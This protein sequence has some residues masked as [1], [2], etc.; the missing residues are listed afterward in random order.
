MIQEWADFHLYSSLSAELIQ[1]AML[2]ST[3]NI[4]QTLTEPKGNYGEKMSIAV[5]PLGPLAIPYVEE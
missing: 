2:K 3:E 1:K 5:L 4:E